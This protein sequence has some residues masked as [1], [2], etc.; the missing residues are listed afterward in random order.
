LAIAQAE[1]ATAAPG[2]DNLGEP[3][4][5]VLVAQDPTAIMQKTRTSDTQDYN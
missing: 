5:P 2:A 1:R 3:P 4:E